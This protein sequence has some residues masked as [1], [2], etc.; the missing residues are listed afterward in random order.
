[1]TTDH[2]PEHREDATPRRR[3]PELI[4]VRE[5]ADILN[6]SVRT[7]TRL[8]ILNKIRCVKV[9]YQWR[10]NRA[11]LIRYAGLEEACDHGSL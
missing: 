7:V 11:A 3:R 2:M 4:D 6:V 1:M 5:A 8:C 10:I 9:G